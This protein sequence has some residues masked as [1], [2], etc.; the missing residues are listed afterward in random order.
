MK[1]IR[2]TQIDGKLPN[3]VLMKLSHYH[4]SL[5]HSVLFE[6]SVTR[7][8]FEPKYDIIYGSAIFSSSAKKVEMFKMQFPNAIVGGTGVDLVTTVE[9]TIGLNNY[10][11]FDYSIYPEFQHSIGFSQRGCR[12]KCGFCVVPQKEGKVF[13]VNTLNQIWRGHD[14]PKNILLLDNDFFGQETWKER[15]IEAIENDFKV[16]FSQGIN[17]RLIHREGAEMLAKMKYYDD[18]FKTKRIYT[19]WDN[20]KDEKRFLAGI[21]LLL[22]AGIRPNHIMVFMLCG[23]WE[24]E[25]FEDI[26]YRFDTMQKMGLMPYPMVFGENK[27]LK[28]FQRWVIRRLYQFTS[29]EEYSNQSES[30]YYQ[31]L[32]LKDS[33]SIGFN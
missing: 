3:L 12:L 33:Y 4:K 17:I 24:S 6:K 28:K 15:C 21:N 23:Y 5:G 7:Q 30:Q 19:A 27:L 22:E 1:T 8:I 14:Y 16:S 25:T 18:Q 29:W 13:Q 26:Y 2:I 32:G 9:N 20:R 10:E 11:F 31:K